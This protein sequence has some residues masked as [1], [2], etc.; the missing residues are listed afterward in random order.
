MTAFGIIGAGAFGTALAD[1]V[2]SRGTEV[3]LWGDDPDAIDSLR[4]TRT[5]E[6]RLPGLKI[7]ESIKLTDSLHELCSEARL[8]LLA[9]PSIRVEEVATR[10]G[11]FVDGRHMVVHAIGGPAADPNVDALRRVSELLR[12]VTPVKRVGVVAGPAL[13][14][15][16]ADRWPC[17]VVV[18]SA[19]DEV[20]A[21]TRKVLGVP[22]V[23]R[24][25][26]GRDV[27]GVELSSALSGAITVAVG[28][29]DGMGVGAGPRAVLICRAVAEAGRLL[30]VSG[31]SEKTFGGLA[32]L[33]NLL[34]RTS[35]D[36]GERSADYQLG[37]ALARGQAARRETEGTRAAR[38]GARL[39]QKLGVRTPILDAVVEVTYNGVPAAKAAARLLESVAPGMEDE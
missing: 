30:A 33:G 32:G 19:F 38:S 17:A 9:V 15:N 10:L 2:A 13:A 26:G 20:I 7:A 39:G 24:A 25:Y 1:V 12:A 5:N 23:L 6:K 27:L 21:A 35:A 28:L 34:V 3:I 37:V 18:A 29:S 8:L 31:A 4:R 22:P 16:L 11:D 14:R 36:S